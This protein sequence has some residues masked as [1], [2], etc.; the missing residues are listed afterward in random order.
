MDAAGLSELFHAGDIYIR[1][2]MRTADI[3]KLTP[4]THFCVFGD[5]NSDCGS[6]QDGSPGLL[7]TSY[8]F[9]VCKL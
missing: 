3:Y 1:H 9:A 4:K 2:I 7:E 6:V 5:V 8:F